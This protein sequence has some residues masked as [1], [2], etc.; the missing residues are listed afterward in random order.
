MIPAPESV[1]A[2]G[3]ELGEGPLWSSDAQC[4]W[5]TDI[6]ARKLFR[7]V[8]ASSAL[9]TWDMPEK[10]GWAVPSTAGPL[11]LGL[12]SG[13]FRF[14]PEDAS[15]S[16]MLDPE[17]GRAGNRLNDAAI[18]PDGALWFGTMDDAEA[19]LSGRLYR[20]GPDGLRDS[21]LPPAVIT[22]GPCF[23]P[24]GRILYHTDT[25]ARRIWAIPLA[26]GWI[27]GPPRL[28]AEIEEGAGF[29][30]G[31]TIDAEGCLWT[32]LFG[33]WG[34]RR[35]DPAGRPVLHLRFPMANVTKI[36][37]G[38]PD[39]RTAYA[40][41]ARKGLDQAALRAQPLAGNLFAFDPGVAGLPQP[42]AAIA[43]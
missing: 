23:S 35:Y 29:P 9:D 15:L 42:P 8:P 38:G 36:A 19:A 41:T 14:S 10:I 25:L 40:T 18:G 12:K 28:F 27:D 31:P 22:N 5:F 39:L 3:A 34:V 4:L 1:L 20:W 16:K 13:I 6:V 17:P 30:D 37:F 43:A 7:F 26:D 2:A 11:L 33:G 32:G 24:D 21:G